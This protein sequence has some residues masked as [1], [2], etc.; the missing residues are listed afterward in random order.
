MFNLVA[1]EVIVTLEDM[2]ILLG[3][4][5]HGDPATDATDGEWADLCMELLGQVPA[6]DKEG[7]W[8]IIGVVADS[9][10]DYFVGGER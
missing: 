10:L 4:R 3:L 8:Q 6:D 2:A 1:S 5:V 7:N 9:V